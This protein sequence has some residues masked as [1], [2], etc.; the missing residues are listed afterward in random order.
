MH[1]RNTKKTKCI[2]TRECT[3][4]ARERNFIQDLFAGLYSPAEDF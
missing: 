1:K 4:L 3:I 2:K